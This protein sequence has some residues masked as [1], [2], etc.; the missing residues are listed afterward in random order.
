[1]NYKIADINFKINAQQSNQVNRMNCFISTE[2]NKNV[3]ISAQKPWFL[4]LEKKEP[5]YIDESKWIKT[6]DGLIVDFFDQESYVGKLTVKEQWHDVKISMRDAQ[7]RFGYTPFEMMMALVFRNVILQHNGLI[8]HSSAMKYKGYGVVFSAASGTGKTTHTTLWEMH[9]GA[10]I[11]NDDNPAIR[12]FE[13]ETYVYGTPWSGK[14]TK[15][16]ND[17]LPLKAIVLLEQ[18]PTNEMIQLKPA[19][20]VARLMPRVFLP[21]QDEA[22]MKIAIDNVS[23][24]IARVP[25]YLLKCRP[26]VEAMELVEKCLGL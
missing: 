18:S 16:S 26:D 8:L 6:A 22:L 2:L 19:E 15:F 24:L 1:M 17:K 5:Y 14:S 13:D 25:I 4:K 10:D 20:A 12:M 3:S 21:Y 11:I 9:R 23:Q 7:I